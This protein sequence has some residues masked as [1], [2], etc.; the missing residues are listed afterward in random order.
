MRNIIFIKDQ[1]S[2]LITPTNHIILK[3]LRGLDST[4]LIIMDA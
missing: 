4:F 3:K 1:V 2:R